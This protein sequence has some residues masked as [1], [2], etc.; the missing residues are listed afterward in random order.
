MK[1]REQDSIRALFFRRAHQQ[2]LFELNFAVGIGA[3]VFVPCQSEIMGAQGCN[4]VCILVS[5][6]IV[7]KHVCTGTGE[8][9]VMK[10]PDTLNRTAR[11]LLHPA[12]SGDHVEASVGVHIANAESVAKRSR[13]SRFRDRHKLPRGKWLGRLRDIEAVVAFSRTYKFR[14]PVASDVCKLWSFVADRISDLMLFPK[15]RQ[16]FVAGIAV[17]IGRCTG[18]PHD[19]NVVGTVSVKVM[20][21]VEKVVGVTVP[22]LR[23]CGIDFLFRR[24][25]R[26]SIPV[27]PIHNIRHAVA[28]QI[29]GSNAF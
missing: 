9:M 29:T 3:C 22:I 28:I 5:I 8:R 12:I 17:D 15:S 11:R 19:Q 23:H 1:F 16:A 7:S 26:A 13:G 6:D 2:M 18:K 21:P 10:F 14:N 20:D 4:N 27:W 24:V 25:F